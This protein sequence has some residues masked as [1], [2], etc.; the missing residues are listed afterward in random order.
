MTHPDIASPATGA[1]PAPPSIRS[2]LRGLA[3]RLRLPRF[4]I[5]SRLTLIGVLSISAAVGVAIWTSVKIA[6]AE[7][8]RRAQN[9]LTINIKLL[10][11]VLAGYGAPSLKDGKLYFGTTLIN[12]NFAPVD[13][14]KAVA[15]GTA[16][17]FLGDLRV[18]TNVMK[19]DGSRAV[20]TKLVPGPAHDSVFRDHKT[21]RG[22]ANIL[23][24]IYLTIY[25]P[26]LSGD[27]VIGIA[28]VG[29]KKAE[30]FSVVQNLVR[31]NLLAGA[32]VVLLAGLVM[33]FLIRRIF[34]PV[35]VIR[36]ELVEMALATTQQELDARTLAT[37]DGRLDELRQTLGERGEPR[38]DKNS[39]FFGDKP[40][41]NDF[42][43][44]DRI[45]AQDG[46][47]VTIF[48]GDQRVTTNVGKED[49]SRAIGTTLAAGPI[50]DRVLKQG[51]TYRGDATIFGSPHFA[52]YEPILSNGEIIG[53]LFVGMPRLAA[54][55]EHAKTS[56]SRSSDEIG[57]M[58]KAVLALGK[59]AT[60]K[61]TAER[62][63]AEQRQ[64]ARDAQRHFQAS[65]REERASNARAQ[66]KAAEEQTQVVKALAHGLA[67]LSEGDL[68][69]RLDEGF[70]ESY[71]Q[72]RD[73]FNAA[74][75][76]LRQT[77]GA[78]VA[79]TREVT[80][81]SG[82]ISGSVSDLSQRTEEQAASL[83]QTSTAMDEIAA[84]AKKNAENAQHASQ[85]ASS[86]CEVADRGVQ[87]VGKTV[88]AMAKIKGSSGKISEI[89]GV[90]DEIARQ[91]NLLA[92]NAAVEAAR[93][94]EAGRGFAVVA[95][96]VRSL[97]QRSAQAAKDIKDLITNSNS[98]V[99]EGVE[100]ADKAGNA[101]TEMVHSIKEVAA[102]ISEIASA[103][104][105]QSSGIEQINK[106]LNQ[107]DEITQQNSALVEQSAA[108]AKMLEAQAATMDEQVGIFHIE[109][110]DTPVAPLSAEP[111]GQMS[112]A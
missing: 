48:M 85:S 32:A 95:S 72:V 91:T 35:G 23:G 70:T 77:I 92:L 103:S 52:I 34:A 33:F 27:K 15:G 97:A 14:V 112:A 87:V 9:D 7:M 18:S 64:E 81:A 89:I 69:V 66:A 22:E 84:A 74:V 83:E 53:I 90:I 59:A 16:T 1:A 61:E 25:E 60:A 100:L 99:Q 49:G 94:G 88:E 37:L 42:A 21:Y 11:S 105:E 40:V 38:R 4:G 45:G 73:D 80:N 67:K 78:I 39:L 47:L 13:R 28:Y 10:D 26:I 68:A 65:Q 43:L 3:P 8:Y 101:L 55:E 20:G 63:A 29:M 82:E 50:Y 79:A 12:G 108:T 6:E 30:F 104:I 57:E 71:R 58:H 62:E 56:D 5:V 86:V 19:P 107:M 41:N 54:A 110:S 102:I 106:A 36:H 17:V 51:K 111:E 31:M 24:E 109:A 96:E 2:R 75:E 44:V 46:T 98:Q 76:R 93:A